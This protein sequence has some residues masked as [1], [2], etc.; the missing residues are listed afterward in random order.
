[1]AGIWLSV[2]SGPATRVGV[3]WLGYTCNK[4]LCLFFLFIPKICLNL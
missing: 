4:S 1:V 2:T 3:R